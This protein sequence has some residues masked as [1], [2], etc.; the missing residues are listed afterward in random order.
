MMFLSNAFSLSML[1]PLPQGG[2]TIKV[3]P[4]S[5]EEVKSLLREGFESAVGHGSTAEVIATLLGLPVEARRVSITL[6]PGDRVVVF[7]LG[8]RLEEGR[9]LSREEV[10]ALYNEGKASFVVVEVQG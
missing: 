9:I 10:I 5:L 4:V 7:Q 6:S 8:V 2:R 1:N 3:R